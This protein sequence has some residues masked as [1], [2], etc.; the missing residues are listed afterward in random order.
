MICLL[1]EWADGLSGM[2]SR[3]SIAYVI[4]EAEEI[5]FISEARK[6]ID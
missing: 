5:S 3:F 1:L 6:K 2:Y 4:S